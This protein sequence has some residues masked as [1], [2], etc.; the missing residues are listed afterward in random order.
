VAKRDIVVIGSSAGG[1]QALSDIV[2]Q[3]PN[4]LNAAVF[5][6]LHLSPHQPSSLSQILSKAGTP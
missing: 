1:V 4:D 6:V 5:I 2:K 3:L